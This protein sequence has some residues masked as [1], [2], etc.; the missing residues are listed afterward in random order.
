LYLLLPVLFFLQLNSISAKENLTDDP[1]SKFT[2][3]VDFKD[4]EAGIVGCSRE[5]SGVQIFGFGTDKK[6]ISITLD[7]EPK[8]GTF[9]INKQSKHKA[10]Y[11][12]VE[13]SFTV[14]ANDF[15]RV[16]ITKYDSVKKQISG[17][18]ELKLTNNK[19][20][21]TVKITQGEFRNLD[22][23]IRPPMAGYGVKTYRNGVPWQL[24]AYGVSVSRSRPTASVDV[25]DGVHGLCIDFPTKIAPGEYTFTQNGLY[26]AKYINYK[27]KDEEELMAK[28]GK[29]MILKNDKEMINGRFEVEFESDNTKKVSFTGGEFT[30]Y[31]TND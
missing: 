6:G 30:L 11:G 14:G 21:K 15:G 10:T 18:F 27:N 13:R 9:E 5:V 12:S 28:S 3:K 22:V 31:Y 24:L 8:E 26:N 19:T 1:K 29:L 20:G 4:W 2:A 17:T 23:S 25:I 16:I 7:G